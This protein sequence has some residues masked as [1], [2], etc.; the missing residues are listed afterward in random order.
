MIA[1][2]SYDG[3]DPGFGPAWPAM[4]DGV[5]GELAGTPA[6]GASQNSIP[7]ACLIIAMTRRA[8]VLHRKRRAGF[9]RADRLGFARLPDLLFGGER[10]DKHGRFQLAHGISWY[11]AGHRGCS[12]TA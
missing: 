10:A 9:R 3:V 12:F 11:G 4:A 5:F 6:G 7:D 2:V 8:H 1:R